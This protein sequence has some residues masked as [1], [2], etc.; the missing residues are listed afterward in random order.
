MARIPTSGAAVA[1]P[2]LPEVHLGIVLA[3]LCPDR[4]LSAS[5]LNDVYWRLGSIVGTWTAE[6]ERLSTI[7]QARALTAIGG[8][9]SAVTKVLKLP[10]VI[11]ELSGHE[12]GFRQ[13][14]DI[15]VVSQLA[16]ALAKRPEIGSVPEANRFICSFLKDTAQFQSDATKLAAACFDA[17]Q[18]LDA[19]VGKSGRPQLEWYDDF[20]ELLLEVAEKA[21][22]QPTF[23]KDRITNERGGWLFEAA[24]Q[25]ETFFHPHMRSPDGEACGKRLET[26][27]KRLGLRR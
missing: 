1:T 7:S 22:M 10:A 23:S 6:R 5:Y 2:Y 19:Q 14:S 15:A 27:K 12:T 9:L 20:T 4:V 13:I 26:S 8:K 3:Q 16:I 17:A 24:Q 11:E 18:D 25:L 21:G